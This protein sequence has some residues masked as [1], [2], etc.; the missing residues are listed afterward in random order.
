MSE[1][2]SAYDKLSR[3]AQNYWWSWQPEIGHI[4]R[5]I[6]P[7]LWRKTDH[8]P[9]KLLKHY[10]PEKLEPRLREL[11]LHSSI[12]RYYRK[13]QEYLASDETWGDT[14]ATL[15]GHQPVA[16]FSAEFGL[17]ES[18]PIYSGGLGVLAGD[19]LKSASDL[20]VPLVAVGLF[21]DE[22]Y[23]TQSADEEGWQQEH[24]T[25]L[26]VDKLPIEPAL[27]PS[28]QPITISVKTRT[29][30]I[31]A[32]VWLINVGRIRLF[33]LDTDVEQNAAED[34]NLTSRLYSGGSRT[35]I[36]QEIMLGIGG[37]RALT[38]LGIQPSV[39]HMNEGH[40]AF[41]PLEMI[42]LRMA[43]DGMSFADAMRDTARQGV[44]TTHTPVEAGHDRFEAD[45]VE[46]H[47]G[48]LADE[49]GLDTNGLLGLGRLDPQSNDEPFCMTVLA[50]KLSRRANAV[51]NL[52]GVVSR[53]MWQ[54][55]WPWRAE[56]EI[57]IGHI[58]NGVHVGSWLSPQMRSIYDRVLP[59]DWYDRSADPEVWSDFD[60]VTA[61]ELWETHQSLKG[62]LISF[63]RDRLK[64]QR[65]RSG[66][67]PELLEAAADALDPRALTIGFAR[68]FAPY[69][70]ADLVMRDLERFKQIVTNS[71]RPVQL[72]Y[73]GKAHPR[74]E[75]GKK[76]MQNIIKLSR[77][78]DLIGRI[79]L[80]ENYDINVTRH[81]IQG[82]DV[83]LN[84][85]R[86][87]LEASGTSGQKVVL[88][89]G[90]NFSVLDGWWAE[91][92]DGKNGFAIGRGRSHSNN[93]IQDQR[94]AE[95]LVDVLTGEIVPLFYE[96]NQDDLPVDWIHM[97]KRAVRTLGWRFGADRMVMD[98]VRKSYVPAAG[99]LSSEM[100]PV[101]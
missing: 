46:E 80:I 37:L 76:V 61:A 78:P 28:G 2:L 38:A 7:Q 89:G 85:P 25:R 8:N 82:V 62:R 81:M 35:R 3:L 44:F 60:K 24:Y 58:T 72:I 43:D 79:V 27:D 31:F 55:L 56:E 50:F 63:C 95:S 42:R 64:Q 18:L 97:M 14:H 92:Y 1:Q 73:A 93:D 65:E 36:R 57:P 10:P 70:R 51:S 23:F 68:R 6:D 22:G 26:D 54:S 71:D 12:N 91:G 74:D 67:S 21:Y 66:T 11:V 40:S 15:L 45:L 30:E 29:G 33:L 101:L 41:A 5:S 69:K 59:A 88:N 20:G 99:G 32:K 100:P 86:R 13:C 49:I 98:Y 39:I 94:D 84:N 9:V 52:H 53:R 87:P 17:H 4:F 83:W 96:R 34:R 16:Y 75:M 19:H 90:L 48:P 47:V 77:D